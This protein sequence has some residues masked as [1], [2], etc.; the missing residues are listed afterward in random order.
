MSPEDVPQMFCWRQVLGLRRPWESRDSAKLQMI[1]DNTCTMGSCI[2]VLKDECIR[3][4]MGVGHNNRLNDIVSVVEPNDIPLADVEFCS[5]SHSD[6]SPKPD[7]PISREVVCDH[8]WR[9]VTLPSSTTNP[10]PSTMN[11]EDEFRLV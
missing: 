3:T 4:P 6:P 8:G 5:P 11:I 2:V 1:L 9:L 10:L 7:N